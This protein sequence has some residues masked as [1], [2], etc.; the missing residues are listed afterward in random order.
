MKTLMILALAALPVAAQPV[1]SAKSGVVSYTE[2]S[3][4]LADQAVEATATSFPEVKENTVL[5]TEEGRAEVLLTMGVIL[6]MGDNTSFKML[7]NRL[8]DTRMELLSGSH[9]VEAADIQKDNNLTILVK[10]A[11][12][13]VNKRGLYRFDVD[14]NRIKVFDGVASVEKSGQT[15]LVSAGKSLALDNSSNS[16]EKFDKEATDALD[17][18]ARRRSEQ[19]AMANPSAAK[20][21]HDYG[22]RGN[23]FASTNNPNNPCYNSCGWRWNPWY[24]MVTYIPCNGSI[25]SPYGWRYFS[26]VSVMRIYYVPPV[27]VRSNPGYNAGMGWPSYNSMGQTSSGYSGAMSTPTSSVASAPAPAA[28][29]TT[30][31]SSAGTSSA[32]HGGGGHGR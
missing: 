6:R 11:T 23:S 5:R 14:Q 2:G 25:Y 29:A 32:G 8:I 4:K 15:I 21:V 12:V 30:S 26:P 31:S 7:T 22:C 13:L 19:L 3:V 27:N 24:G 20:Q 1:I 10:E 17:R 16:V 28:A 18:W 9:I